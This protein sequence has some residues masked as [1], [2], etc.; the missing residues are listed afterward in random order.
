[1]C[2]SQLLRGR[3]AAGLSVSTLLLAL[4]SCRQAAPPTVAVIPE[5]TAQEIWES[6]HA[7]AAR[8]ARKLG[9]EI[10]WNGPSREDDLPRQIQIVNNAVARGVVGLVLTPD[11]AVA[12]ITPVRAAIA[13]GIPI[14]IVSSPLDAFSSHDVMFVVNDDIAAGGM[15]ADRAG[16]YLSPDGGVAVLGANPNLPGS[17]Q[18]ADAL[19]T[20]LRTRLPKVTVLERRSTSFSFDEAEERAEEAFRSLPNLQVVVSLN[21]TQT[22]AAYAAAARTNLLGHIKIIAC[23]QDLDLVYR[24]R[25]GDIDAIIAQDTT[26]MGKDAI[27]MIHQRLHDS[28]STSSVVVE[29]VLITRET[30]DSAQAQAVL[31]MNWRGQ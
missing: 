8:A 26:T 22:R 19:E 28:R 30:V 18:I 6:E 31:D 9:W 3:C 29:P 15:A 25:A 13:R 12:L 20:S 14:V 4:M 2:N 7:G 16:K 24:L 10:Y 27:E 11:H 1:M 23:D 5:T 21:V 17:I